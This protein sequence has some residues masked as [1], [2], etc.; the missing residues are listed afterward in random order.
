[1]EN[2]SGLGQAPKTGEDGSHEDQSRLTRMGGWEGGLPN[3][4]LLPPRVE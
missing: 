3:P 4:S 2:R 1:M